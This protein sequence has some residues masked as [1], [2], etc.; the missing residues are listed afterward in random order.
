M[1]DECPN[2]AR[3]KA[4]RLKLD[5][6]I[7]NQRVALRENWMIV[8]SREWYVKRWGPLKNK[9]LDYIKKQSRDL[10]EMREQL[11]AKVVAQRGEGYRI[12]RVYRRPERD[13]GRLP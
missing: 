7:H 6:R 8:E 3:L 4:E 12:M 10:R 1:S 9:Y 2:C 11:N 13:S 5:R